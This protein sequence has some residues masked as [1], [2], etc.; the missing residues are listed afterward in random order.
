MPGKCFFL[1]EGR[2]NGYQ[3]RLQLAKLGSY[4]LDTLC[5]HYFVQ[6]WELTEMIPISMSWCIGTKMA[7]SSNESDSGQKTLC[8]V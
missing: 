4:D 6:R 5:E 1:I 8:Q 7:G 2:T 3:L